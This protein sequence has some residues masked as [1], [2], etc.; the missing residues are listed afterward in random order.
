MTQRVAFG[1]AAH[2]RQAGEVDGDARAGGSVSS[3]VAEHAVAAADEGV[4]TAAAFQNVVAAAAVQTVGAG[5]T[6]QHVGTRTALHAFD[7]GEGVAQRISAAGGAR[8][9][10]HVHGRGAARVAGHVRALTAAQVVATGAAFEHV[11]SRTT[12]EHVGV[13]VTDQA[14][15]EGT[16]GEVFDA[17]QHVAFGMAAA[18]AVADEADRHT[19]VA[20]DVACGVQAR[21]ADEGVGTGAAFERVVAAAAVQAVGSGITDEVVGQGRA[22]QVFDGEKAVAFGV[23]AA[24]AACGQVH[25]HSVCR[26]GIGCGVHAAA[27]DQGVCARAAVEQVIACTAVQT[28]HAAGAD[29]GVVEA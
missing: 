12:F 21:A 29:Q 1:I 23:A 28:V 25:V 13:G 15:V 4:G 16:A 10:V 18:G 5:V 26:G 9:Q 6:A 7:A 19:G 17:N 24:A 2:A 3:G 8:G 20:V 27:T 14:V 11:I 22:D